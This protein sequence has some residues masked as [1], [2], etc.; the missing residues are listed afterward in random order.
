MNKTQNIW[1]MRLGMIERRMGLERKAAKV[2]LKINEQNTKYMVDAARDD[3][4]ICDVGQSVAISDKHFEVVKK[5]VNLGSLM[6][7]TNDMILEIERTVLKTGR[8]VE[9]VFN[10]P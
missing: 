4:T 3:R 8:H 6:T 9:I 2:G 10:R 7:P 5:F 1:L